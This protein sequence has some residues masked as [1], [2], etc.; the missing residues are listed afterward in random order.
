MGNTFTHFLGDNE[1][2]V[3][4]TSNMYAFALINLANPITFTPTN[5]WTFEASTG[6]APYT[7]IFKYKPNGI[8]TSTTLDRVNVGTINSGTIP[9]ESIVHWI[10]NTAYVG[11]L[12]NKSAPWTGSGGDAEG[13]DNDDMYNVEY[14]SV[15]QGTAGGDPHI[16]PIF[17][18]RYALPN[19]CGSFLLF[20]NLDEDEHVTVV[21]KTGLLTEDYIENVLHKFKKKDIDKYYFYKNKYKTFYIIRELI[22]RLQ[23]LVFV[24]DMFSLDIVQTNMTDPLY[25]DLIQKFNDSD[26]K[27]TKGGMDNLQEKCEPK[28]GLVVYEKTIN[29]V[30]SND[31]ITLRLC[32][33]F[34][35]LT[36]FNTVR[37]RLNSSGIYY[38]GSLVRPMVKEVDDC[39]TN[40][41]IIVNEEKTKKK[42][43]TDTD[44]KKNKK[45]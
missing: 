33:T 11:D 34:K 13:N 30:T 38:T 20:D 1:L 2:N 23:H 17:G 27:K 22:I 44:G 39:E 5:A 32:Y 42:N 19:K 41:E 10:N 35:K 24:V 6:G 31:T 16:L 26:V 14:S 21:G 3:N 18:K 45:K 43:T 7:Y 28:D 8:A 40:F 37:L 12:T 15:N 4:S 25:L 9:D 29:I 36:E